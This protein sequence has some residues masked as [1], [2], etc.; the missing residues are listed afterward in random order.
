MQTVAGKGAADGQPVD[1][2]GRRHREALEFKHG[3]VAVEEGIAAEEL[4]GT[5]GQ[6]FGLEAVQRDADHGQR[7]ALEFNQGVGFGTR[8]RCGALRFLVASGGEV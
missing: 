5:P 4:G 3:G 6:N 8:H 7:R 2:R 1:R